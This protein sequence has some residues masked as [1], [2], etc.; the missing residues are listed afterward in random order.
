[1]NRRKPSKLLRM[2]RLKRL[3]LDVRGTFKPFDASTSWSLSINSAAFWKR[4]M[5]KIRTRVAKLRQHAALG[6]PVEAGIGAADH[7]QGI[8]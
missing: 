2:L 3:P 1:M 4:A 6:A 7:Q 8:A 5:R